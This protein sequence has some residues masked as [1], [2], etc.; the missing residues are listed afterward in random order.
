MKQNGHKDRSRYLLL[1]KNLILTNRYKLK[2]T[3]IYRVQDPYFEDR[4]E[5][6]I[7]RK[8]LLITTLKNYYVKIRGQKLIVN[9]KLY[10]R[11]QLKNVN[12]EEDYNKLELTK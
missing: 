3:N 8:Q 5:R 6:T 2:R 10:F 7:L 9:N 4:E 1:K 12:L 11:D